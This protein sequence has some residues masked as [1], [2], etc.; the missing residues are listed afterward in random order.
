MVEETTD[1]VLGLAACFF[2][3][4]NGESGLDE[5]ESKKG[6][7]KK[8]PYC[9]MWFLQVEDYIKYIYMIIG[10]RMKN[11]DKQNREAPY[12]TQWP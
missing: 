8:N 3:Q 5:T 2:L 4:L 11:K 10:N 6:P 1:T 12:S 7:H 9:E